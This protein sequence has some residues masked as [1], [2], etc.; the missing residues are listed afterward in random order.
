M[1]E[2]EHDL[3]AAAGLYSQRS[4][5][6]RSPGSR[7]VFGPM[8]R[9][10]TV[11]IQKTTHFAGWVIRYASQARNMKMKDAKLRAQRRSK[12]VARVRLARGRCVTGDWRMRVERTIR[13]CTGKPALF[14]KN[15]AVGI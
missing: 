11:S 14:S 12:A 5:P 2:T 6:G 3:F 9:E 10:C 4:P 8:V 15:Y 13:N 7:S 1:N